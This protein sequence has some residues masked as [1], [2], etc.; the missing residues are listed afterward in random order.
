[1]FKKHVFY[2]SLIALGFI[3][4][5]GKEG[6]SPNAHGLS[7][8][9]NVI[10]WQLA[11]ATNIIPGLNHDVTAQ[12]V[13]AFIWE[14]LNG[15]NPKTNEL[16][17][18]LA[19]LPEISED[20][21]TY[22]YTINPK[23][24]F[25]DGKPVTGDDVVFSFKAM[26]N[27][28]Q[29]E[30]SSLKNYL[31]PI[32][33]IGF[34]GGDKMKVAFYMKEPYFQNDRV[35]GGGYVKIIPKHIFDPK[36]LTDKMEWKDI[37][38]ANPSNKA[39]FE[40]QA[41][42]FAAPDHARDPKYLIGSG[43]YLFSEWKTN[44]RITVKLD[45]N[46][47]GKDVPWSEAYPNEI[48]LKTITDQN[49]AITALKAKDVDFLDIVPAP[50]FVQIDTQKSPFIRKQ[51]VFY[52]NRVFIQWNAERPLFSDKNVRRALSHLVNRD[53]IIKEVMKGLARPVN[54][55]INFTQPFYD[56]TL[57]PIA[58]DIE[59][60]KQLLTEAGWA[61]S[62]GDG[63]LDKVING[64]K[65][66]FSFYFMNPSGNKVTEQIT[67]VIAESMRKAGID[68]QV[69]ALEWSLWVQNTRTHKFDAAITSM[70]GNATED[71]PYQM[72]HSSQAKNKGSNTYSFKN[73][74]VDKLLEM[75]RVEFD[76]SK[77]EQYMKRFQQIVYDEQPIT[78]LW[79]APARIAMIDRFDNVDFYTQRPCVNIPYWI[80]RGSG[81]KPLPNAPSTVMQVQ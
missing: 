63:I 32:D 79:S 5:G 9:N 43:P 45:P 68:A 78:F 39:V 29:V 21:L 56:S 50:L 61:D 24:K 71:D 48:I 77:R 4:C 46:Y 26:M 22:T 11:D 76:R 40:E 37:K 17:A 30:T 66:P 60:A 1:M 2:L 25:S 49:A 47:W 7:T 16:V 72:F 70:G 80:V 81:V 55:P 20:H 51:T 13:A 41:K 33:S 59:K 52:N 65:T 75:N 53:Q 19:S 62:D 36:G 23:A 54:S 10:W 67:L 18:G 12:Y 8:K 14:S 57:P 34:V 35:L 3:G 28:L 38:S 74:E 6:G 64:K 69:T 27:P 31:N 42:V 15:S 73:D 44:D 58:Y